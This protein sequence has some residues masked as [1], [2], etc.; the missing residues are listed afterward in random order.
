MNVAKSYQSL[1]ENCIFFG[2]ASDVETMIKEEGIQVIVDLRGE[3]TAC[4]DPEADVEWIQIPLGDNTLESQDVL[5][6]QAIDQVVS[7]YHDGKKVALHC[8]GGKGRTGTVAAGVLISLGICDTID[9]AEQVA[10]QIRSVIQ[11]KPEQKEALQ[12]IYA[13]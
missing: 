1:H 2:G 4:A 8:G 12:K 3:A 7:A 11:I 6:K 10:K 13:K 9:D 5:F